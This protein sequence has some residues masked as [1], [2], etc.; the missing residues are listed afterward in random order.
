MRSNYFLISQLFSQSRQSIISLLILS[1]FLCT[2]LSHSAHS[3][4]I[5]DNV[6]LQQCKLCQHNIDTPKNNITLKL[7]N[8][9][10]YEEPV[11]KLIIPSRHLSL[12]LI[13]QLRAPPFNK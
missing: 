9:T 3:Q 8:V 1:A 5:P 7:V 2:T 13:P 4:V 11:Q 6:E 12:Y 10:S